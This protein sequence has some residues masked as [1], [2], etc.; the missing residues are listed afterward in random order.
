[1]TCIGSVARFDLEIELQKSVWCILVIRETIFDHVW[2]TTC[3]WRTN[4]PFFKMYCPEETSLLQLHSPHHDEN[5]GLWWMA[6]AAPMGG[7]T[8]EMI[9][10]AASHHFLEP[11]AIEQPLPAEYR[12]I[13]DAIRTMCDGDGEVKKSK[14]GKKA[15]KKKDIEVG[16]VA[17]SKM[18]YHEI[19]D[20]KVD[21]MPYHEIDD[22]KVNAMPYHEI[23][24][25]KVD[26]MPYH[27]IDVEKVVEKRGDMSSKMPYHEIDVEKALEK[28]GGA[29]SKMPYHEIDG[30]K[31]VEKRGGGIS[32][33][34]PYHESDVE[35][36]VEKRG[37]LS[38]KM[39][40]HEIDVENGKASEMVKKSGKREEKGDM[41]KASEVSSQK[42]RKVSQ[43]SGKEVGEEEK[44][45]VGKSSQKKKVDG[46]KVVEKK[47]AKI[48]KDDGNVKKPKVKPRPKTHPKILHQP[49]KSLNIQLVLAYTCICGIKL[50]KN[51]LLGWAGWVLWVILAQVAGN[52]KKKVLMTRRNVYSRAYHFKLVRSNNKCEARLWARQAVEVWLEGLP[53]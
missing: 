22:G 36:V 35:K 11:G 20:G 44:Q 2:L 29:S 45:K 52:P 49:C 25:E 28:R 15:K 48:K 6:F 51:F 38:S 19:D 13:T 4:I 23:D 30:E 43:T 8:S 1:M 16:K 47:A 21:A 26:D 7:F 27:E 46:K 10:E 14:G 37:K 32:S 50:S 39:P 42:T 18:S 34:M 5:P 12:G 31:V 41:G 53:K 17:S 24:V 40:Y 33:K 9:G 3:V